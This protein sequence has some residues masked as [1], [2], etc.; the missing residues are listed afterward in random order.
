VGPYTLLVQL[1]AHD[2]W[3]RK[4]LAGLRS[5]G[6]RDNIIVGELKWRGEKETKPKVSKKRKLIQ[7][8]KESKIM[9]IM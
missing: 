9:I 1:Q 6:T 2:N 7:L 3:G 5:I 8:N 4:P